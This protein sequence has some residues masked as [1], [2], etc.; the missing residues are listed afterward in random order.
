MAMKFAL[1]ALA[2]TMVCGL[3]LITLI[4]S[5]RLSRSNLLLSER[6]ASLAE[7]T[8]KKPEG[9]TSNTISAQSGNVGKTVKRRTPSDSKQRKN[10][11]DSRKIFYSAEGLAYHPGGKKSE[12]VHSGEGIAFASGSGLFSS[13]PRFRRS[14]SES[15]KA[16]N[17]NQVLYSSEA[18]GYYDKPTTVGK[19]SLFD[20]GSGMYSTDIRF[21]HVTHD[22]TYQVTDWRFRTGIFPML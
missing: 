13:D 15:S 14:T 21:R 2:A 8:S 7:D 17:H 18:L 10:N 6:L 22:G 4:S 3:V 11:D 16:S 19:L 20:G 1:V 9:I 5:N 12:I